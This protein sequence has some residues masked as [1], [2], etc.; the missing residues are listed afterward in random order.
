MVARARARE[1]RGTELE[2]LSP[3]A[4]IEDLEVSSTSTSFGARKTGFG[5][6]ASR[7]LA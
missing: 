4:S 3:S 2:A 7:S 6:P 5:A 1:A